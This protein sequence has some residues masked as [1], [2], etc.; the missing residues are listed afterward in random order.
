MKWELS[1]GEEARWELAGVRSWCLQ[2][3][4][5]GAGWRCSPDWRWQSRRAWRMA[6]GEGMLQLE[7]PRA[8]ASNPGPVLQ[9]QF[10]A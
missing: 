1:S 8:E 7:A 4:R 9:S 3:V 10:R 6:Q 2:Q 5:G